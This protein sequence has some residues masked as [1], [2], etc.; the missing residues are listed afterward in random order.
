MKTFP[1]YHIGAFGASTRHCSCKSACIG[2]LSSENISVKRR[3][4]ESV[5]QNEVTDEGRDAAL[6]VPGPGA[7]GSQKFGLLVVCNSL[8]QPEIRI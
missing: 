6:A 7:R 3:H 4:S 1:Q 5:P 2:L 8:N